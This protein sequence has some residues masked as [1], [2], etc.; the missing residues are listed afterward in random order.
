MRLGKI[1]SSPILHHWKN[2]YVTDGLIAMW[3]GI[4]NAG[5]GTHAD[6]FSSWLPCVGNH[7]L[8]RGDVSGIV[9]IA[10]NHV[11]SYAPNGASGAIFV[12]SDAIPYLANGWTIEHVCT[13]VNAYNFTISCG[14]WGGGGL[15]L[16]MKGLFD[17]WYKR[18]FI[19]TTPTTFNDK[20]PH[21]YTV[22]ASNNQI[23]GFIGGIYCGK[24][25]VVFTNGS[26]SL[27]I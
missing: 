24:Y 6:D 12:V 16:G 21:T 4:W 13:I 27:Q 8:I 19:F 15:Y 7:A 18:D 10:D 22:S 26:S 14:V 17:Y 25:S 3:D 1:G 11:S 2:P 20:I 23:K 5:P 9:T